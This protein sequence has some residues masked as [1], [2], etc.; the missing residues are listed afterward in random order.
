MG[1]RVSYAG[2]SLLFLLLAV[3]VLVPLY[4]DPQTAPV[5]HSEWARMLV[6]ALEMENGLPPRS[7]A[8]V[9]FQALSWK[10]GLYWNADEYVT[11][12]GVSR[13][14]SADKHAVSTRENPG[15]ARYRLAIIRSGDY[16]VRLR[17][18]GTGESPLG[19]EIAP[20]ETPQPVFTRSIPAPAVA[21]WTEGSATH[22]DRGAYDLSILL[23]AVT[24]LE[25][26][27]VAPPC[28]NPIEPPGGWQ[29]FFITQTGDAATTALQSLDWE[30]ELPPADTPA[31]LTGA[32]FMSQDG[33]AIPVAGALAPES[34]HLR[35]G[36]T[37]LRATVMINLPVDGLYTLSYF[38]EQGRGLRWLADACL[39]AVMCPPEAPLGAQ[40][41]EIV[42]AR[43]TAGRHTLS[44]TLAPG[45]AVQRLRIERKKD[46]PE[47]YEAALRRLG[48]DV[49]APGPISRDRAIDLMNFIRAQRRIMAGLDRYCGDTI[50]SE[51][52]TSQQ[53]ASGGPMGSLP[54]GGI[55]G[56]GTVPPPTGP[57]VPPIAPPVIP[58]QDPASP[59]TP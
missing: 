11:A 8:S 40:W 33:I 46:G 18:R 29:A 25:R 12:H 57:G 14:A 13:D 50:E 42:T 51:V 15:E 56:P 22:L 6:R 31:E 23:P 48:F 32:D 34:Y 4:G 54:E 19:V 49:G 2:K 9:V 43:F 38:G 45:A 24:T 52:T 41:H 1:G 59:V 7:P 20:V 37:G 36:R 53:M 47:D 28:L 3:A 17:A 55:A 30:S 26:V 10:S 58:P 27:E 35:A 5:T 39:K 21:T 44:V 16:V